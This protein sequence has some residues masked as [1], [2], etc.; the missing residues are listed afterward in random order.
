VQ[1]RRALAHRGGTGP[2]SRRPPT[3]FT[4]LNAHP[5]VTDPHTPVSERNITTVFSC[6]AG[7]VPSLRDEWAT[8]LLPPARSRR[9]RHPAGRRQLEHDVILRPGCSPTSRIR[10]F[11]PSS[12]GSGGSS[13]GHPEK[14]FT[15]R[16]ASLSRL[17][18][19]AN[20]CSSPATRL[21]ATRRPRHAGGTV[22][23]RQSVLE[24]LSGG[25]TR[26]RLSEDGYQVFR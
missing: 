15:S 19:Y 16:L 2:A 9:S 13:Q 18:W 7:N 24:V 5:P 21:T 25:P 22:V 14:P 1:V 10:L 20:R 23:S 26:M 3:R 17:N 4:T 12:G 8:V 6:D 11:R